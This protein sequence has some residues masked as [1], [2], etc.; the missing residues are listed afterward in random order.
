MFFKR[1]QIIANL[2]LP[3]LLNFDIVNN[4][5]CNYKINFIGDGTKKLMKKPLMS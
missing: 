4:F 3:L 1:K 2:I 5:N